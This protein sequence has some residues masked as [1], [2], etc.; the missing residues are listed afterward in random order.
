MF[1]DAW[2]I[3]R[4]LPALFYRGEGI[5]RA[6]SKDLSSPFLRSSC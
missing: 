5:D 4:R 2:K 3:D 6:F 1:N